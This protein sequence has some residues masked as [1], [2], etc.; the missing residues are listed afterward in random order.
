MNYDVLKL[1]LER[2][3][4]LVKKKLEDDGGSPNSLSVGTYLPYKADI[5]KC[6]FFMKPLIIFI[7][8]ISIFIAN[9]IL[10]SFFFFFYKWQLPRPTTKHFSF[11]FIYTKISLKQNFNL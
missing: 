4:N 6:K 3:S 5:T 1:A 11:Q 7:W 9:K 10:T 2:L 8:N